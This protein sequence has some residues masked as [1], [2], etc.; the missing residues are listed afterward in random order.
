MSI[1]KI[2]FI[3]G[4]SVPSDGDHQVLQYQEGYSSG[5]S[6]ML[7]SFTH[8]ISAHNLQMTYLRF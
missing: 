2:G 7:C 6:F 1:E 4:C 5:V 3:L 8:L